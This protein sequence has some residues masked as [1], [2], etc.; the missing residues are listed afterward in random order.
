MKGKKCLVTGAT[1]GIGEGI[2]QALAR[3]GAEV[4]IVSRN[5]EKCI[6]TV[7]QIQEQTR[8]SAVTYYQADLSSQQKIRQLAADIKKKYTDLDVLVNN[9]GGFFWKRRESTDGI[10]MTFALNHLNYFLLTNLLLDLLRKGAPARIVNTT[11]GMHQNQVIDFND[12]EL[13]RNYLH[14]KAYGKSKLANLYFT[15]ELARRLDDNLVTVNAFNPG[16]TKSNIAKEGN[17]AAQFIGPLTNIFSNP[18]EKGADTGVY[19]ASS[20][21]VEGVS[22]KYFN[23]RKPIQSS[24]ISYDREIARQLWNRCEELTGMV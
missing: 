18:T 13:R 12:L 24:D 15:Y 6:K 3:K 11:S 23:E 7:S 16:F 14:F 2:A 4:I 22:G 21:E 10:E 1:S 20:P 19:L 17:L 5:K 8:N 9:A